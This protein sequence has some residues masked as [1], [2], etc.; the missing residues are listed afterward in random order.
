[1]LV[2]YRSKNNEPT[3]QNEADEEMGNNNKMDSYN[4]NYCGSSG[5]SGN[6]SNNTNNTNDSSGGND[7]NNTN[8]SSSGNDND[9]TS[10]SSSGN[11]NN[12]TNNGDHCR[13]GELSTTNKVSRDVA[14]RER[15][16]VSSPPRYKKEPH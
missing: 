14:A 16:L 9:D 1:M 10:N 13:M 6:S 15:N 11:N 8:N 2:D 4:N 12:N 7:N 3:A 5:R